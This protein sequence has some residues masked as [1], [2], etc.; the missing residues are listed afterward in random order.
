MKD[1]ELWKTKYC[2]EI[3]CN[4]RDRKDTNMVDE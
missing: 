1:I 4:K 3:N 2:K